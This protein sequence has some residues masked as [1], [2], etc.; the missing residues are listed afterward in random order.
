MY[1][2]TKLWSNT[3]Y[4]SMLA[5][6]CKCCTLPVAVPPLVGHSAMFCTIIRKIIVFWLLTWNRCLFHRFTQF[7][8][9]AI[10]MYRTLTIVIRCVRLASLGRPRGAHSAEPLT[11]ANRTIM[12]ALSWWCHASRVTPKWPTPQAGQWGLTRVSPWNDVKAFECTGGRPGSTQG[13]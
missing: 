13:S 2:V 3:I 12:L 9:Q 1:I 11:S 5:Q 7:S 8:W 6:T 10:M 4:C